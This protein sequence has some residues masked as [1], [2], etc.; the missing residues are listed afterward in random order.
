MNN[1]SLSQINDLTGGQQ[2]T[3]DVPCPRCGP[4]R[5]ST[6]NRK[7]CVCRIWNGEAF[8]TWNCARCGFSGWARNGEGPRTD[9]ARLVAIKAENI[10]RDADYAEARLALSRF[11]FDCS[12]PAFGTIVETYLKSAR[13]IRCRI[14]MTL[15]YLSPRKP[16]HHPTMIAPFGIPDEIRPGELDI[17]R[18]AVRGVHLTLLRSD[19]G[20][21][22]DT[23]PN[24][25]MI[26]KCLGSP[27]VVAPMNDLLGL[28]ITEGIEDALSIHAATGLGAWAAGAAGRMPALANAVPDYTDCVTIVA[29]DDDAGQRGAEGLAK[30]LTNRHIHVE[31]SSSYREAA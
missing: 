7:R 3:F 15:R 11:L 13:H 20:R 14:P 28:S 16:G 21:K 22:A 18:N 12:K 10:K 9:P 4:D 5:K 23:E 29:D 30:A 19:G 6:R 8:A 2:G 31:I 27:I 17:S 25:I 24:K 26:G 1:L